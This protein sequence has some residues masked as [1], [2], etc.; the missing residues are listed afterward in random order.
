MLFVVPKEPHKGSAS[1]GILTWEDANT[2][3]HWGVILLIN[4]SMTL[5]QASKV[6]AVISFILRVR[7]RSR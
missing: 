2:R 4:G 1:P 7:A 5:A 6:G 3:I